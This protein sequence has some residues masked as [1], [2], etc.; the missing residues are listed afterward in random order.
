MKTGRALSVRAP[1]LRYL[2]YSYQGKSPSLSGENHVQVC[3]RTKPVPTWPFTLNLPE[4]DLSF[5][6]SAGFN[7][8]VA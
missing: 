7:T 3:S 1:R 2:M 6:I 5:A 8:Q 4:L